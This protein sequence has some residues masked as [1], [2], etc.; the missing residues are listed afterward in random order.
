[1][2]RIFRH[3]LSSSRRQSRPGSRQQRPVIW[4]LLLT[5]AGTATGVTASLAVA[6]QNDRDITQDENQVIEELTL[7]EPPPQAPVYQP[8]PEPAPYEPAPEPAPAE[9]PAPREPAA[10]EPD[11]EPAAPPAVTAPEP[12]SSTPSPG[13]N[14]S[15]SS[16]P[17]AV[18]A[19]GPT[20]PY[21]LEFNR[22]PVVG[23]RLR[24]QGVFADAR[25]G[26]T[27][28]RTWNLRSAKVLVRFQ[29]SPALLANRSNLTVRVNGTSVGSVPLNRKQSEIGQVLLNVPPNLIQD[30]NEVTLVAQQNNSATCTD[31]A[32][33]TLWTEVLP[34][35]KLIFN[36]Q[37][38]PVKLD[39]TRY[40]YPFFDDLSLDPNRVTYLLPN[41]VN[42]AWLTSAARFQAALGR[43]AEF[44]PLETRLVK[45]LNQAKADE[46][47]VVIGTPEEQP[48]LKSL[49]LPLAIADNQVLDASRNPLPAESGIL[50]LATT[51][52]NG[53]PV[54]IATGNG[55]EGVNKAVQFLVQS[56]DRQIGTGYYLVVNSVTPVPTPPLRQW[57]GYLPEKNS[58]KLREL[59]NAENEPFE[60]VTVR[61]AYAP[62]VEVNFRALPDDQFTR[63]SSMNLVYSYGPQV[64]PRLSTVEVRLD[65]APIGGK[66]LTSE[67][68]AARDTLNVNLPAELVKPDSKIQV[69]FNLSPREPANCGRINDQQLWGKVHAD[70]NFKL[71]RQNVVQ[72]P[73]LKLLS[74]GY[75]FA[76]PQDLSTTA[77]VVPETPSL[78]DLST[79]LEF[80]ERLGR[81]SQAD[82]V[83]IE[84]YTQ[85]ALTTEVKQRQ[86]LVGIG[87]RS[88]FP[89]P[90][91]FQENGFALKNVFSRKWNQSQIQALPDSEGVIKEV[92]SPWNDDRV[93]LA[94]SAQTEA[95]LQQVQNLLNQD[96]LF[97][98]LNGDTVLISANQASASGYDP[99]A[100]N[101]EFLQQSS[102]RRLDNSNPFS[103]VSR[104]LQDHWFV[105]PTGIVVFALGL[106]GITQ[107]YLKRVEK[108]DK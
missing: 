30:F 62:P 95:G 56:K 63:G 84:A 1:M 71:K 28:P 13:A 41:Q 26:F 79:L 27:R 54:L 61:G 19:R 107:L 37:P 33:P 21:V 42:S 45:N 18:A 43:L 80:S 104:F 92:I 85:D 91:A 39:F 69:A 11:P 35:S 89:F 87:V 67:Q 86:N 93:L 15:P 82:T 76:A 77:I 57:P 101:L 22:S 75:P 25:L 66:R 106:Y 14:P 50:M 55:P 49:K 6:Q 102:Q 59:N 60:D 90:E 17:D 12:A 98:Q 16:T 78:T 47:L 70:T 51:R 31:P 44:R 58:F 5:F 53:I 52:N 23:N 97:F 24:L 108:Q 29:H 88:Q 32:D 40:P 4:L 68:G 2:Q 96:P 103:K 7:P 99:D 74:T 38:K 94:L 20:V 81:L 46:R 64:N 48:A 65:G 10:I 9:A 105:L 3:L 34:D 8:A 36:Y 100:Y 83:K 72:I 73:D